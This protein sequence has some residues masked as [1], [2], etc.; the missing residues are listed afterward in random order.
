MTY[1]NKIK[2]ET[3]GQYWLTPPDLFKKLDDEFHFNFDPCPYPCERDG[4]E[5]IRTALKMLD[6]EMGAV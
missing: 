3:I 1:T 2:T 6:I 4:C 5:I